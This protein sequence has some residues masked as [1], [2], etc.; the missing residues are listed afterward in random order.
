MGEL[1]G[2]TNYFWFMSRI[3]F[4]A[5]ARPQD[6]KKTA[7]I[8]TIAENN[9]SLRATRSPRFFLYSYRRASI[10]SRREALKA[11][12]MPKKMPTDAEKPRPIANDH[13]GSEIGNPETRWTA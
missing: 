6:R 3:I 12:Y 4:T 11:G 5:G 9:G 1:A 13:H 8:A 7:E 2:L 10:G